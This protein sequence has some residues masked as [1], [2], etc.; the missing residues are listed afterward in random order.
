MTKS[1][2]ENRAAIAIDRLTRSRSTGVQRE[3]AA[4]LMQTCD[5]IRALSRERK[6]L[7]A[8]LDLQ[9]AQAAMEENQ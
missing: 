3:L 9:L 8:L 1:S 5:S 4:A 2:N 6:R 7:N